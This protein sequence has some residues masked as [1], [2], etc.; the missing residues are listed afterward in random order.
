MML[1]NRGFN[2]SVVQDRT[3]AYDIL[4]LSSEFDN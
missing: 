1:Q 4:N 2:F 3:Q